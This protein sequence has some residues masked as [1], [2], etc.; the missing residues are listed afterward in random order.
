[1][2]KG[3]ALIIHQRREHCRRRVGRIPGQ[4]YEAIVLS[5]LPQGLSRWLRRD[6]VSRVRREFPSIRVE[7][8][9]S[10]LPATA[11]T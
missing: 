10:E 3:I 1:M 11:S 8:V 7:H 4:R 5:T 6:V 2:V 9:V